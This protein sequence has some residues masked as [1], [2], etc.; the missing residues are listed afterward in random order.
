M[1]KKEIIQLGSRL[2]KCPTAPF[3][4]AAVRDMVESICAEE[5]LTAER[6][7]FGNVLIHVGSADHGRP[8]AFA[9]HMDH[10]GFAV[11]RRLGP[12][13]WLLRFNGTVPPAYFR[14]G[15][16]VRLL[17]GPT[18]ARVVRKTKEPKLFE[19]AA[20]GEVEIEPRFGVWELTDFEARGDRLQGRAC[21][22]LLGVTS[23]LAALI[24]LRRKRSRVNALG[25]I[26]RAEEVG[27]Q[28]ALALAGS[29]LLPPETLIVSLETSKE[30]PPIR[31]GDGVII[32]VGDRSS[33][34]GSN[35]TRFL[36]EVAT[37]LAGKKPSLS[38]QRALMS[39]GTCEATAYQEFGY[40]TA[41]VCVALGNYHNCSPDGKIQEEFVSLNDVQGM[42]RLLGESAV[43]MKDY[44]G[45][46]GR[47]PARLKELLRQARKNLAAK[48]PVPA[49]R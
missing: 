1:D 23:A 17:P 19:V 41:A 30:M 37:D 20:A 22:D 47:L 35:A 36:T 11:E 7:A 43:R 40:E 48:R 39:G 34:F 4:E 21:D 31:M 5:G 46:V 16:K 8:I 45:L 49:A 25:L 15:V 6:D 24:D 38:F 29:G 12:R 14:R 18:A 32:R 13:R 33:I 26:S 28:G 3:H 44:R 42:V 9:A 27:F 2:M 10:P